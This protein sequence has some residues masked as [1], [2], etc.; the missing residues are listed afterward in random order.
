MKTKITLW[1]IIALA[2]VIGFSMTACDNGSTD[3]STFTGDTTLNGTWVDED[4]LEWDFNNGSFELPALYAVEV[5]GSG[6][7]GEVGEPQIVEVYMS[8]GTY[9]ANN[10]II[11]FRTTH[12]EDDDGPDIEGTK[13]WYTRAELLRRWEMT[14]REFAEELDFTGS[15]SIEGDTLTLTITRYG[16]VDIITFTKQ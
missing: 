4:G 11:K 15:Y 8:K 12:V 13:R 2:A 10:G 3:S 5:G 9:T 1:G 6:P 14:E 16:E 7:G